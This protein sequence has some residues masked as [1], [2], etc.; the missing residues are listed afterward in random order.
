MENWVFED[1]PSKLNGKFHFLFFL[2]PPLRGVNL[3]HES[4]L[5]LG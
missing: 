2:K 4:Q 5:P 1:P 3:C